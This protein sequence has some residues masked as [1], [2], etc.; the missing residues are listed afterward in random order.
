MVIV[1]AGAY[2]PCVYSVVV[3]QTETMFTS[4]VYCKGHKLQRGLYNS[5]IGKSCTLCLYIMHVLLMIVF[6]KKSTSLFKVCMR[7]RVSLHDE[8][9][10]M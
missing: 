1:V 8:T 3:R 7:K 2:E 9:C 5:S 10:H 6:S 4:F